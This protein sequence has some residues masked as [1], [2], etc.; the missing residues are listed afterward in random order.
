M[1]WTALLPLALM[2]PLLGTPW[3]QTYAAVFACSGVATVMVT[4]TG[5]AGRVGWR[6]LGEGLLGAVV[7]G[8]AVIGVV[9]ARGTQPHDLLEGLLL[10]PLR[11]PTNFTLRYLWPPGITIAAVISLSLCVIACW[12]RR[13]SF[14][15]TKKPSPA[16][17]RPGGISIDPPLDRGVSSDDS[18]ISPAAANHG[19]LDSTIAVLRLVIAAA[20][21]ATIARFPFVRPDYAT[22][23]FALP[24]LWIFVWPLSGEAR[25]TTQSRAWLGLLLLGQ[26]LHVFPVPGSQIAWGSVLAVPLAGMGAWDAAA[27]LA[28]QKSI[29]WF[30]SPEATWVARAGVIV[31]ILFVSGRFGQVAGRYREGQDIGLPGAE[32]IRIP[33]RSAALFRVLAGNATAHADMLFSLPGMFSFNLWTDLPTPTRANVTH[34]FSLFDASRQQA[35]IEALRAQP[36]ACVIVDQ[37]HIEFLRRR[38]L[39]PKGVLHDYILENFEPAFAVDRFE[40]R[41]HRGRQIAPFMLGELLTRASGA[42]GGHAETTLLRFTLLWSPGRP[43]SRIELTSDAAGAI[44]VVL[45]TSNARI[46]IAP[47]NTQGKPIGPPR[48]T[49]WP[50]TLNGPSQ[51]SVYYNHEA[52]PTPDPEGTI[53]LRDSGGAEVGLARLRP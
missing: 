34:W 33:D 52:H 51:I 32:T 23:G 6:T 27:W 49:T 47:A 15:N 37:E 50:F 14:L 19:W 25:T 38:N 53:I 22:F 26:C 4:A 5:A 17:G 18:P 1:A 44:P 13:A 46:A 10:G 2:R 11:Q 39:T 20:L 41:V 7:V 8:G 12:V 31:L 9:L 42:E 21:G 16:A 30:G 3:V 35:I 45:N 43:I 36:R 29:R 48:T 24:C 40:F 28:R